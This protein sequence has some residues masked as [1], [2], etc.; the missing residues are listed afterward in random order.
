MD[1]SLLFWMGGWVSGA[2]LLG[3]KTKLSPSWVK[4]KLELKLSLAKSS[5]PNLS[6]ERL[7]FIIYSF[8]RIL[9]H[10]NAN[11][12]TDCIVH[13]PFYVAIFVGD[14]SSVYKIHSVIHSFL[15]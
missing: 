1:T 11:V 4:L 6:E 12:T 9:Q 15:D 2:G 13:G 14:I 5:H 10:F 3:I 8:D 7:L